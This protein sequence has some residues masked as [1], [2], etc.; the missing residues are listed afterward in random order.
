MDALGGVI[1]QARQEVG[2]PGLGVDIVELGGLDQGVDGGGAASPSSEPAKVQL[3]R[4]T[5]M[6]RNARSAALFIMQRRPLSRKRV[7][8]VQR[9][10]L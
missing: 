1:L 7:S 3:W 4:P 8:A 9:L 2:E 5:A 6:A 10:K